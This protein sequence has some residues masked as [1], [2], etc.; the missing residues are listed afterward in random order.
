MARKV[1][2][3]KF[4]ILKELNNKRFFFLN[5]NKIPIC[6]QCHYSLKAKLVVMKVDVVAVIYG[7]IK[8][9]AATNQNFYK[10]QKGICC[11]DF[12]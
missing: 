2:Q 1:H 12:Q 10:L 9:T 11:P 8:Y 5:T 7:Q 6:L 4:N 3:M